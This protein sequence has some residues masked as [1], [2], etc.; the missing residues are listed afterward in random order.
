[1]GTLS[2]GAWP[3][4]VTAFHDNGTLN[5]EGNAQITDYLIRMGANGLFTVCMSSEMHFLD[6]Q[7]KQDLAKCV[8]EA[9]NG[10]VQVI[11]SGHTST[12]MQ[13]QIDELGAIIETGVDAVVL[14]T[15][16]LAG[17]NDGIDVF[18]NNLSTILKTFPE[19]RFAAY[20]CPTPFKRILTDEE[21]KLLADTGR[22]EFLKDVSCDVERYARRAKIVEGSPLMLFNANTQTYL[23]SLKCGYHGYSGPMCNYHVDVFR[24]MYENFDKQPEKAAKLQEWMTEMYT[25]CIPAYP[26]NAKYHMSLEGVDIGVMSFMKD[27]TLFTDEAAEYITGVRDRELEMRKYLGIK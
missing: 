25:T 9:A 23:D 6:T 8:L 7:Q 13:A 26:M 17:L 11:A 2:K 24:W 4:M 27:V 14:V 19:T 16:C 3:T 20:E 15:N 18:E 5:F 10:R 1:M 22:I 21:V 12:D